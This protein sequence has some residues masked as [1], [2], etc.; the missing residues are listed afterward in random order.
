MSR[1]GR[2]LVVPLVLALASLTACSSGSDGRAAANT[3]S[4][5]GTGPR[6]DLLHAGAATF[7]AHGSVGQV[8]LTGAKAGEQLRLVGPNAREVQ[9]DTADAQGSL[10]FRDVKPGHGYRVAADS[11]AGLTASSRLVVTAP[12]DVPSFSTY[13][14]QEIKP[15]Y[16]YLR[17][18]DGTLLSINVKLPGPPDKGPYPTVIEY[19]GYSPADPDSPQPSELIAGILGY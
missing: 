4:T 13:K 12:G 7:A 5:A 16:G 8:W 2:F 14:Q 11:G 18:R 1:F 19:S 17:T 15:G 10:I 6:V 3:P 9:R